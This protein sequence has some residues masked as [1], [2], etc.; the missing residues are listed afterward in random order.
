MIISISPRGTF[1]EERD[2][3]RPCICG[4]HWVTGWWTRSYCP[5]AQ[6]LTPGRWGVIWA[7]VDQ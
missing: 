6:P 1:D 3:L 2:R 7:E 4:R 5:F